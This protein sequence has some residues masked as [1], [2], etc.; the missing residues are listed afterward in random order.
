MEFK[1]SEGFFGPSVFLLDLGFFFRSKIVFDVE[2][3]ADLDD[4]LILDL[5]GDLGAG[6]LEKWLNIKVVGGHDKFE[7]LFL[8]KVDVIGVPL[9]NNLRHVAVGEWLVD[10]GWLMVEESFAESNDFLQ[11]SFLHLWEWDLFI[12][13]RVLNETLDQ[14]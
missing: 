10:F 5:R 3:L 6:E 1:R 2:I 11:D 7:E 13:A 14:Y 4:G 9:V 12:S 8:L